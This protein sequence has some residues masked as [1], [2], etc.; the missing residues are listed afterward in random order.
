[1]NQPESTIALEKR[2]LRQA[3]TA[4][5]MQLPQAAMVQAG[6]AMGR[7]FADHPILAFAP[8]F[9]GY[10]AMRS[11]PD[12]SSIFRA[13]A[14]YHKQMALPCVTPQKTLVFREWQPGDTLVRHPLG[15]QEP[16]ADA[17]EIIPAIVLVPLLA[18][19]SGGG[20]LGYGGGYYDRTMQALRE[21]GMP[22][23]FIGVA[24]SLQEVEQVP[25]E[26]QDG[27]LDGIMTELGVSIF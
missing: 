22:P 23:L 18:F 15:M 20:R 5:R 6:D 14:R 10:M 13:M 25:M 24:Y 11:E 19:D 17:P 16:V 4:K 8:S 7:H 1:M 26:P 2:K 3:M 12:I 9:A 27:R 21:G